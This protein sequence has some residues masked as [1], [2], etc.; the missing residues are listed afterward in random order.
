[1]LIFEII[2]LIWFASEIL[3]HR[4]FRSGFKDKKDQDKGSLRFIWI[5]I[6]LAIFLAIIFVN[7][8]KIPV[9]KQPIIPYFGLFLIISGMILRFISIRT[10]GRF[11]TVDVT[12]RADHKLKKDGIYRIIRHPAY[13][14]SLLSFTGFGLSL[15]N[16]LSL[17]SVTILITIA[18]LHRI[19][20]EEK[21][22]TD[23][24]GVD[25][26]DYKRKTYRLIPWIY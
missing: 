11:F 26:L 20:I 24:F 22:L 10:L 23:Q 13:S 6:A 17:L 2:W 18:F 16:W 19:K 3:L 12:I 1:M 4:L 5:M 25:Y 9:T 7:Y 21:L 15:N 8:I 14:G